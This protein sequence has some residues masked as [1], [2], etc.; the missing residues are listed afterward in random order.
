MSYGDELF[1][2]ENF[3]EAYEQYQAAQTAGELDSDVAG[4]ANQAYLGCY[5]P[6]EIIPVATTPIVT[7]ETPVATTEVP[8]ATTELPTETPTATTAPP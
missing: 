5:P 3:C 8:I 1:A 6:T 4:R 2:E 7:V